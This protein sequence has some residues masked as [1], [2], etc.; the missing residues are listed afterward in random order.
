MKT[1][2]FVVPCL[3]LAACATTGGGSKGSSAPFQGEPAVQKR[4]SEIQDA[5][6]TAMDCMKVKAGEDPG[7]GG[8]FAVVADA[9][10]KLKVDALKFD[11]PDSVKQCIV[12]TGNKTTISALPGPS[13]G[14][15]WEFLPPGEKSTPPKTP[16]DF[17]TNMQPLAETM[18]NQVIE[19][20]R[21]YLGVDFGATI[22][23]AYYLYNSGQA[24]APTV[25]KSDAK[26]G[27]FDTCVQEMILSTKFPKENV[28]KPFGA[29]GHFKIGQYG[30]TQLNH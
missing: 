27:S 21:R 9:S 20:G 12:D 5:A 7:K 8:V 24:Y 23:I 2:I 29:T 19:C 4:Q 30:D 3:F 18:Q 11:G 15:L 17:A 1:S 22:D 14:S 10:G 13:V 25:I 16:D 6:K 26:D 28:D